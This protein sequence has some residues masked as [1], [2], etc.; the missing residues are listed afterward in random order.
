MINNDSSSFPVKTN[1]M[2]EMLNSAHG[3][4]LLKNEQKALVDQES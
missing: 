4:R 1:A 3:L 2:V